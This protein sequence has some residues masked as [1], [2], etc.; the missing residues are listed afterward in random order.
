[1]SNYS[2]L[3]LLQKGIVVKPYLRIP[4]AAV[5]VFVLAFAGWVQN[6]VKLTQVDGKAPYKAE[7]IRVIGI[8]PPIGAIVGWLHIP[9]GEPKP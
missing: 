4:I 8:V 9:D 3:C 7:I 2:L 5:I 6:I 1:M